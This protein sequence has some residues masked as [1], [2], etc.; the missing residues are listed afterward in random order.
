M[1]ATHLSS[2]SVSA[3][4]DM[5]DLLLQILFLLQFQALGATCATCVQFQRPQTEQ[6]LCRQ[7]LVIAGDAA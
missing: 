7:R 3:A 2:A 6:R 4:L 5:A 1:Q